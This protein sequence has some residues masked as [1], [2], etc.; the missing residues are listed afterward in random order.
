MLLLILVSGL[1]DIFHYPLEVLWLSPP[2]PPPHTHTPR[3]H[4]LHT[5]RGFPFWFDFKRFTVLFAFQP[6][7]RT[8]G[9]SVSVPC[10][11]QVAQDD[12]AESKG[13]YFTA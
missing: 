7:E 5:V 12:A 3:T 10:Q 8:A 1:H 6:L 2:P 11:S 9:K 4:S 13:D